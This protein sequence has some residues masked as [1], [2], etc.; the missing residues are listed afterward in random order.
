[1]TKRELRTAMRGRNRML[2]PAARAAAS[3]EIF[4]RVE[5]LEAF[6]AARTVGL[7]CALADEPDTSE[8]LAR[9][10]RCKRV[11]VPRVE[12]ETM[13]FYRY[14]PAAMLPG[15][16]GIEEP[17]PEAELCDPAELDLIVVPG[18]AFTASGQRMGRGRGYY[19]RYLAQ[20]GL[21]AVK[22][23]V[24]YAHQLVGALPVE[25]H[26]VAMDCVVTDA[27]AQ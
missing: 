20:P 13:R 5:S 23:G 3:R 12:G 8:A 21:H 16:F 6:A 2:T 1:M 24:G 7:F 4:R 9:W 26:D 17:G 10:G 22:V 18:M 19:D 11:A 14:D 25:P 27:P 15:A